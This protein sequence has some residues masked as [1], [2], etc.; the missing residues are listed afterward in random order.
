MTLTREQLIAAPKLRRE[1]VTVPGLGEVW[2]REL[3]GLERRAFFVE[4]AELSAAK[5]DYWLTYPWRLLERALCDEQGAPILQPGDGAALGEI[6]GAALDAAC[7]VA[8]RLSGLLKY[9]PEAEAGKS[10][11]TPSNEPS[12]GSASPSGGPT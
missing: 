3:T 11:G 4:N 7:D 9:G 5:K 10:E 6:P 1:R 12:S 8:Y 2:V